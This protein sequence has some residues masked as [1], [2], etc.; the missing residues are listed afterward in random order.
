VQQYPNGIPHIGFALRIVRG[1]LGIFDSA[2]IAGIDP[3]IQ[4]SDQIQPPDKQPLAQRLSADPSV[5]SG[6]WLKYSRFWQ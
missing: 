3:A 4:F 5:V 6:F 1:A 2:A